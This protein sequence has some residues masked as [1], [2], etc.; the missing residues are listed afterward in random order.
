MR[1]RREG[2]AAGRTGRRRGRGRVSL[3]EARLR[4][5]LHLGHARRPPEGPDFGTTADAVLA[6]AAGGH[7]DAADKPLKW[8]EA[9]DNKAVD[10][11]KGNPGR[12]AKL[13]L[14]AHAMG[15]NPRDF[16]G[17]DVV[18]LLAATGPKAEAAPSAQ[19]SAE[20]TRDKKDSGGGFSAW[21]IIGIG[22]AFGAG[23]GFLIS[24]RNKK[25]KP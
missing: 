8:L 4:R 18:G 11:A 6:L 19:N 15:A 14:A 12:L 13:V 17:A 3:A 24:G 2:E 21:W 1:R 16:G 5:P 20:G 10:W 23:I 22:L 9:K 7:G 25:N